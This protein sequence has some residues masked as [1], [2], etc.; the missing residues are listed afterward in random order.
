[1]SL[2][3]V[4]TF[5]SFKPFPLKLKF[6]Y[7]TLNEKRGG[8]KISVPICSI[9]DC[10]LHNCLNL[11]LLEQCLRCSNQG[12]WYTDNLQRLFQGEHPEDRN[13]LTADQIYL[14]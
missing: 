3:P 14:C 10:L 11:I 2:N 9:L 7:T 5:I 13:G 4:Q 6:H 1:M 8:K 12:L